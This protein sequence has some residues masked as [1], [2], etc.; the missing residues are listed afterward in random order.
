MHVNPFDPGASSLVSDT[1]N[2]EIARYSG[3]ISRV[4]HRGYEFNRVR[5]GGGCKL[6]CIRSVRSL[7]RFPK[8]LLDMK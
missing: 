8:F 7:C 4:P 3:T 5:R 1:V 2:I 6:A